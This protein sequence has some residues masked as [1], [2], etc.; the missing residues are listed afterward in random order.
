M[1]NISYTLSAIILAVLLSGCNQSN[2]QQGQ[3]PPPL[4]IDVADVQIKSIQ[5]WHTFTTRLEAPHH[6]SLK[7]RVSGQ[8]E[9]VLFQE[10]QQV[11]KGQ[12]L[13]SIDPRQFNT[14]VKSLQ[15]QLV[16]AEAGLEQAE[17]EARRA[18]HLA[19]QKAMSTEQADQ[20][21]ST[22]RQAIAGR[23]AI[24]A[25]LES[26]KLNLEFSQVKAPISGIISRAM[27]TEGNFVSAGQTVLTTLVSDD[28]LYAYFDI[29]ERTWEQKF[30]NVKASDHIKVMMQR[31]NGQAD[32]SGYIDFIDNRINPTT[33]TLR[34]RGVFDAKP[35]HLKPG[36]FARL[37][38]AA[39]DATPTAIVPERAIGTDL[40]NRF[41]LV[42]DEHNTLQYR[43]VVLGNR[44]GQLR[45]I[46]SGLTQG[47]RVAANGPARVGPGMPITPN[48]VKLDFSNIQL[49]LEQAGDTQTLSNDAK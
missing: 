20:R 16:S 48:M 34:V 23:D 11:T 13:F 8:I 14:E 44:Y 28:K 1:K 37:S 42:V 39:D 35:Y 49:V 5:S 6:V 36:A 26:A 33:G 17:H 12:V 38:L 32:I 22:L 7:P 46:T 41:V 15:A 43:P 47:D 21:Q 25:Q 27:A 29:D 18:K 19:A 4:T 10:G 2:A 9:K 24:E 40:K 30:S 3:Q 31:L 45:A